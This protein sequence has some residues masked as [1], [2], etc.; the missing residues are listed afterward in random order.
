MNQTVSAER[1][2]LPVSREA[3]GVFAPRLEGRSLAVGG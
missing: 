1:K 2:R 3:E